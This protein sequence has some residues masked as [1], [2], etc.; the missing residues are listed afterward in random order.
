MAETSGTTPYTGGEGIVNSEYLYETIQDLKDKY[1]DTKVDKVSGKGLS[2]NDLTADLKKKYDKAVVDDHIH[3][4]KSVIDAITDDKIKAWDSKANGNHTHSNYASTVTVTGTGNAVTNVSQ[5]GNTITVTKG[6][7]FLTAHPSVTKG[8]N[9]TATA[10]PAFG[11]SFTA[12]SG[13]TTDSN[14]H[15]TKLETKTVSIPSLNFES[16]ALDLSTLT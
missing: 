10:N 9:T 5:S 8:T 11:G 13:I 16:T 12:I 3:G 4:N 6:T 2:T 14:G 7:T 15:V 1:I